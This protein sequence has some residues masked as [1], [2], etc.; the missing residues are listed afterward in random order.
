MS[1]V[2]ELFLRRLRAGEDAAW[3]ELADQQGTRLLHAA[4]LLGADGRQA[5][6]LVQE[7][8]LRCA[9]SLPRFRGDCALSSWLHG[10]LVNLWRNERR[11]R[12]RWVVMEQPPEPDPLPAEAGRG[13]DASADAQALWSALARLGDEQREAVVRHYLQDEPVDAIARAA[14][15]PAGTIKSRLFNARRRLREWLS[16][17]VNPA[18]R[19]DTYP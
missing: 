13:L 19:P 5:E 15:V 18:R 12:A 2:D 7:T 8:F 1:P 6:D 4:R 9:D 10:I 14:G 17:E 3:R 11:K 16:P